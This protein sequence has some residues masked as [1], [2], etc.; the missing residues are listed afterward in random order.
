MRKYTWLIGILI[1]VVVAAV[2]VGGCGKKQQSSVVGTPGAEK[3]TPS[4]G[5][6]NNLQG[7]LEKQKSLSSYVMIMDMG[8]MKMRTS[9]KLQDGKPVAMKMDMG[10]QGWMLMLVDKK[11]QYMYNPATKAAMAIPMSD[12]AIAAST[13]DPLAQL[14]ALADAKV[15]SDA[16]DGVD[17]L[18][19]VSKGSTFWCDKANGLPVQ[20]D[21]EG[22]KVK[23]KYEQINSV[24]DSEFELPAG[25]K[26]TEMPAT[27]QQ[28]K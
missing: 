17:C 28:P 15:S 11:M 1:I 13:K 8:S 16:V 22:K 10:S 12:T 23:F 27:P 7:L 18:K 6:A 19:V 26:I 4:A 9:A 5:P 20:V 3:K 2:F 25:I 24:P 21:L 14:K